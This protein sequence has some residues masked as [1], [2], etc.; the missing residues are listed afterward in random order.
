[1]LHDAAGK[2]SLV[3]DGWLYQ[4]VEVIGADLKR[5][6]HPGKCSADIVGAHTD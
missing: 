6:Q 2:L 3:F 5:L 1:M 4:L